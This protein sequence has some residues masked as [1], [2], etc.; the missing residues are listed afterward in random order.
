MFKNGLGCLILFALPF[1]AIGMGV[2]AW[3]GWTVIAHMKMRG[4]EEVPAKI[5]RA[6]LK[7]SK[8]RKSTTYEVT[9]EYAYEYG[10]KHYTGSA[11][12]FTVRTM[13]VHSNRTYTVS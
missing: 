13:S 2:G 9:A 8:G 7:V 11:S 4:W 6:D 1:A 5:V 10:S 3:M 12:A